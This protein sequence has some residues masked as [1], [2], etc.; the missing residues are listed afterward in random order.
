VTAVTAPAAAKALVPALT[1]AGGTETPEVARLYEALIRVTR[2]LR[3][4]SVSALSPSLLSALAS[5][6]DAGEVRLGDLAALEGVTPATLS[7]VVA[8]LERDGLV[9]RCADP[10]DRRSAFLSPTDVGRR[11]L[12]DARRERTASLDALFERLD[13]SQRAALVAALPALEVLGG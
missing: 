2:Y 8:A 9:A 7:R 3:R 10:D 5:V 13:E 12:E 1:P 4:E 6:V 11:E